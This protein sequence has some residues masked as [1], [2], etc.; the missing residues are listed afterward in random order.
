MKYRTMTALLFASAFSTLAMA[1]SDFTATWEIPDT[2]GDNDY[3]MIHLDI[4]AGSRFLAV[5]GIMSNGTQSTPATGSCYEISPG[6]HHCSLSVSA[7]TYAITVVLPSL[8]GTVEWLGIDGE[9][10]ESA[11][12]FLV[13]LD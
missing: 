11:D 3:N 5:N 7:A 12:L 4:N 1:Q 10:G 13:D 2:I 9:V 6:T 8:N